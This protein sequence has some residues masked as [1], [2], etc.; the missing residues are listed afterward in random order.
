MVCTMYIMQAGQ[1]T[2]EPCVPLI[3]TSGTLH[4]VKIIRIIIIII[5]TNFKQC[6]IPMVACTLTE[7][8]HTRST[9]QV[10][11]TEILL[12]KFIRLYVSGLPMTI[13]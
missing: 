11:P 8:K 13:S 1:D 9:I 6:T 7:Q 12:H 4:T 5:I 3:C 10:K 2:S